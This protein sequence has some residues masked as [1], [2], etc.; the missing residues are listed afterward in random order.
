MPNGIT[1]LETARMLSTQQSKGQ[2]GQHRNYVASQER[3]K[4]ER[5]PLQMQR[6][7]RQK[8]FKLSSRSKVHGDRFQNIIRNLKHRP[9]NISLLDHKSNERL[10]I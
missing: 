1:Y 9:A 7:M 3:L 10:N 4:A 6:S 8:Q 2:L 5:R